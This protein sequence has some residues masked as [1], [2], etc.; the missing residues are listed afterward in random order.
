MMIHDVLLVWFD[1]S[2]AEKWEAMF[3]MAAMLGGLGS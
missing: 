2:K 3:V 1:H